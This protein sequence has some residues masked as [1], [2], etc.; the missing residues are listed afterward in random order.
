[1]HDEVIF[2]T[3]VIATMQAKLSLLSDT[4]ILEVATEV[5]RRIVE[6][7]SWVRENQ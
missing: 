6:V 4:A 7:P 3:V 2:V 5:E 1:M